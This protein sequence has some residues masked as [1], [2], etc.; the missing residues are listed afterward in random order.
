MQLSVNPYLKTYIVLFAIDFLL[1]NLGRVH[2]I[3]VLEVSMIIVC[4]FPLIKKEGLAIWMIYDK[5]MFYVNEMEEMDYSQSTIVCNLF[6]NKL[7][8]A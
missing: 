3:R 5:K 6:E 2:V 8:K 7:I 1:T 4:S